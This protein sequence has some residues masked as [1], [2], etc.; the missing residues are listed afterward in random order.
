MFPGLELYVKM[1]IQQALFGES[2]SEG[3]TACRHALSKD[4]H[5]D[6]LQQKKKNK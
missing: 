3:K 1:I 5:K 4:D 2:F 6:E